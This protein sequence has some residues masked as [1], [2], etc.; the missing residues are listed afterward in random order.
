MAAL[1]SIMFKNLF[2]SD[3]PKRV[4]PDQSTREIMDAKTRLNSE[5][6]AAVYMYNDEKF[7]IC[8]IAGFSEHGEPIV[9]DINASDEE[10]GLSLCDKLLEFKTSSARDASKDKLDDWAAFNVSGS[11]TG[12]AFESK[13]IFIYVRTVNTA[14]NIEAS[15]RITNYNSLKALNSISNGMRH[16]E[17]GSAIRKAIEASKVLRNAG[18]L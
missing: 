10:L 15:P 8:S 1:E 7:I 11:K 6:K 12:K 4:L 14:I 2:K 13:S 5:L 9:L 3:K 18:M 17:I 16:S